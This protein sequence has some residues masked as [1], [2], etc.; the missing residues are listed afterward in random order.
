MFGTHD[1]L[2]A[3]IKL[4]DLPGIAIDTDCADVIFI[5]L[6]F[7]QHEVII[8]NGAPCESLHTGPE[9]MKSIPAAARAELFAILPEL[10]EKSCPRPLAALCRK[11]RQQRQLVARHKKN[12]RHLLCL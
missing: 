12:K 9:A 4:T 2:I 10:M 1:R 8:T 5:Q 11:N 7:D 3:A 6:L